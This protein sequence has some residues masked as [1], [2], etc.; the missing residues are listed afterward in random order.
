MLRERE[1]KEESRPRSSVGGEKRKIGHSFRT[2]RAK[3]SKQLLS[4]L[5]KRRFGRENVMRSKIGGGD[6][7]EQGQ[8]TK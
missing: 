3:I 7:R 6:L 2:N 1:K 5:F 8:S 4:F